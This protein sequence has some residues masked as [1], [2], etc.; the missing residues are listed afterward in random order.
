MP[1]GEISRAASTALLGS[2][3]RKRNPVAPIDPRSGRRLLPFGRAC[4]VT[5]A[6][7]AVEAA[8]LLA[9]EIVAFK[10]D[11]RPVALVLASAVFGLLV[12]AML[13]ALYDAFLV[14]LSFS[15]EMIVR[16]S[17]FGGRLL[18][19]WSTV[20]SV[21]Y[22][23]IGNWFVFRA[24]GRPPVRV[25]IYRS[26]LGTFAEVAG[27][28]LERSPAGGGHYLLHEKAKNPG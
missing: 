9:L 25:S 18:L 3:L 23:T 28:G 21:E 10:D 5:V 26:G 27:R 16:E 19:P 6:I 8:A 13:Y 12:L 4:R 17:P 20:T 2:L 24:P 1:T 14:E 7:F 11:P 22:S 15:E